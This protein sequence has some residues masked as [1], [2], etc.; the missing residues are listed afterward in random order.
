MQNSIESIISFDK[1]K[2]YLNKLNYNKL[3]TQLYYSL[4]NIELKKEII[5]NI[6]K[7]IF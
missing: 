7:K 3:N 2:E 6:L 5:K 4:D 1:I